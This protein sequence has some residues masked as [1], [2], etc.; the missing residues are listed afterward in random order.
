MTEFGLGIADVILEAQIP[1]YFMSGSSNLARD[2]KTTLSFVLVAT[3]VSLTFLIGY[4]IHSV[5]RTIGN[6]ASRYTHIV[7]IIMESSA[8][9]SLV[10]FLYALTFLPA[11]DSDNLESPLSQGRFYI[12][13]SLTLASGL[14]P[15]VMVLRLALSTTD[16]SATNVITHMSSI[17]FETS[18]RDQNQLGTAFRFR[19]DNISSS[20]VESDEAEKTPVVNIIPTSNSFNLEMV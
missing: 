13:A 3:T 1:S 15:T 11:F 8:V 12:S 17:N 19:D 4:R 2:V 16:N 5:S 7:T 14:A 20:Q 6:L 9:Y 18:P 10:L